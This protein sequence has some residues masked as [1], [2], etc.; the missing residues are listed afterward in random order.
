MKVFA[1][2]FIFILL[3]AA[4]VA[5]TWNR[6]MVYDPNPTHMYH[7]EGCHTLG[8]GWYSCERKDHDGQG[9]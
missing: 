9:H 6:E 8:K 1:I 7:K 3:S 2:T 4:F 5:A